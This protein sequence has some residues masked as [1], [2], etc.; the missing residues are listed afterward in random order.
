M[1]PFNPNHPSDYHAFVCNVKTR[2]QLANEYGINR[3]TLSVWIKRHQLLI[4]SGNLSIKEQ[5]I[6]YQ[7]FG[8]PIKT[9]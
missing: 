3:K 8:A 6:I 4:T 5:E 9:T 7:T 1:N 2:S